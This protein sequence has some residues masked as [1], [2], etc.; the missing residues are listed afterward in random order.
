MCGHPAPSRETGEGT[1]RP[2]AAGSASS[3]GYRNDADTADNLIPD[4]GPAALFNAEGSEGATLTKSNVGKHLNNQTPIVMDRASF[5]AGKN[6]QFDA[7]IEET[8]TMPSLVARGPHA[9]LGPTEPVPILEAGARTGKSTTDPRAGIGIGKPG[10]PMFTLQAG[11][12][13]AIAF[14]SRDS[15]QDALE[16]VSPTLRAGGHAKSHPNGGVPPAVVYEN[17][18]QDSRVTECSVSPQINAKAGT[19]GGNLPLAITPM[20]FKPAHYTRGKDGAPSEVMPPLTAE[21]DKGDTEAVIFESRFARN[22]RGAPEDVC[23]PLKAES[24]ETGKGDAAPLVAFTQNSRSEVRI[25]GG[26]GQ[27]T[28]ALAA[29]PGAQQQNYIAQDP[30]ILDEYNQTAADQSFPLRTAAGDGIPKL[31]SSAVR[32]LTPRE[33]ERLQG[34]PDD[35]TLIPWGQHKKDCASIV[36]KDTSEMTMEEFYDNDSDLPCNCG[37]PL[38]DA[39]DGP[40]Y[41][42]LGNSMA[43]VVMWW[44]GFRIALVDKILR[45]LGL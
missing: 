32:R 11:K 36:G 25:I 44:I 22:G 12:Q 9:V 41:K 31:V 23:P 39:P 5:N 8:E 7:K 15:G 6:A 29:E 18:A 34:F 13:H 27:V 19:G 28:G 30:M 20:C 10:D 26:D 43:V 35:Y 21:A 4:A 1:A 45:A 17:H 40:R 38:K 33:C 24:G 2:L 37:K 3:G 16:E 14:G 42:A